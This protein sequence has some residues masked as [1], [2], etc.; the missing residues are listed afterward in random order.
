MFQER[1]GSAGEESKLDRGRERGDDRSGWGRGDGRVLYV[2]G[3]EKGG[4]RVGRGYGKV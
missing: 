3:G 4:D 1:R 2:R